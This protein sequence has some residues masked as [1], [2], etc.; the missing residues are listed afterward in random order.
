MSN[1]LRASAACLLVAPAFATTPMYSTLLEVPEGHWTTLNSNTF[2]SQWPVPEQRTF[3]EEVGLTPGPYTVIRAFGSFG[4]DPGRGHLVAFGGGHGNYA[5][6]EV[7]RW[8]ADTLEWKRASLPS[9][10]KLLS[11]TRFRGTFTAI[12]GSDN[13]PTSAHTYDNNEFLPL[14][15]RFITLGGAAWNSGTDFQDES[16]ERTGPYLWDPSRGDGDKVG[17]TT[18]SHVNPSQFPDVVGGQMWQNRRRA[19]VREEDQYSF[20]EGAT[21]V[22]EE[23]GR[24][25]LLVA[26]RHNLWKY[27]IHDLATPALDTW[28]RVG[29]ARLN[30]VSGTWGQG[31]GAYAEHNRAFVRIADDQLFYYDLNTPDSSNP[32][33]PFEART[34]DGE[35]FVPSGRYGIAYDAVRRRFLIWD[36]VAA[37][38]ALHAPEPLAADGWIVEALTSYELPGIGL[39]DS[40]DTGELAHFTGVLG[41]WKYIPAY[42]VFLGLEDPVE[43]T[44]WAYKP[45][46]WSPSLI[47][48]NNELPSVV[49]LSA[50]PVEF[51]D[52]AASE[53]SVEAFDDDGP[54]PLTYRWV[55][56]A[57]AGY[58][59][60]A[61]SSKATF[62][63]ADVADTEA[64]TIFVVISDGADSVT[65]SLQLSVL[66]A[67]AAPNSAPQIEAL[68]ATPVTLTDLESSQLS[69]VAV[70]TD[71]PQALSYDW[72]VVSGVGSL[73]GQETA[74]P[75]YLPDDVTAS[76]TVV[77]AVTVLRC[78]MDWIPSPRSS[79]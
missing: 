13:A 25:V 54:Q 44:V 73:Q 18:G 9:E 74:N 55:V 63:P 2:E 35:A 33:V 65:R 32:V 47:E 1:C 10:I 17:G 28:E 66:D 8:H 50:D 53:L 57:D 49:S 51:Y 38:W 45:E 21:A 78:R 68:S 36:G 7:Y 61:D 37:L 30:G 24:D 60:N 27:T 5:G 46:G 39:P 20:I 43:G 19:L 48:E 67:E 6:N 71:G 58:L 22:T 40:Y 76:E 77:V 72:Q 52:D 26:T 64:V 70:D 31:P 79:S 15:D 12:D 3:G 59:Q 41:K 29:N 23:N 69:V 75:I 62:L 11:G 4:W 34:A 56:S 42:D 16:L 14:I